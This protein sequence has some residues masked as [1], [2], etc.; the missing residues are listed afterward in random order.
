MSAMARTAVLLAGGRSRRMGADKA[1]MPHAGRPLWQ[2]Q[3]E[4]LRRAGVTRWLLACRPEQELTEPAA[5]WSAEH[6]M[7]LRLV[8][9]PSEN[10]GGVIGALARALREAGQGLLALTVDMPLVDACLLEP[11]WPEAENAPSRCWRSE[12][13]IEPFPAFYPL[14]FL[15]QLEAAMQQ[16]HAPSLRELLATAH[17]R[18]LPP[19]QAWKLANWNHPEDVQPG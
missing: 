11:L 9:D 3:A 1:W 12:H 7:E 14:S 2:H 10:A 15:P 16:T 13:G 5:A 17:T 19:E 4:T 18:P 8:F 6:G